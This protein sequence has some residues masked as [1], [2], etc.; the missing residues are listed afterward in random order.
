M[1]VGPFPSGRTEYAQSLYTSF[2]PNTPFE[3]KKVLV[4]V[5]V[6]VVVLVVVVVVVVVVLRGSDEGRQQLH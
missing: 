4:E 3:E 1:A 5:V 6:V 2:L